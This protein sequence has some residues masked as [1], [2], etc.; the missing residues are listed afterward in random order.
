MW[1]RTPQTVG[2]ASHAPLPKD[3]RF[4]A[5]LTNSLDCGCAPDVHTRRHRHPT[6]TLKIVADTTTTVA[7]AA[8][9]PVRAKDLDEA[10]PAYYASI[11]ALDSLDKKSIQEMKSF[12]N[13]PQA[14]RGYV[15]GI[16][17]PGTCERAMPASTVRWMRVQCGRRGTLELLNLGTCC[18]KYRLC[19]EVF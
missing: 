9:P 13:P 5:T 12:S 1:A 18:G 14:R 6:T 19:C 15:N 7:T 4:L 17:V 10:M 8:V 2:N 11:K 3:R 16:L